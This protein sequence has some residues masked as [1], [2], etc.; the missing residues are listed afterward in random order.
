MLLFGS[1][2]GHLHSKHPYAYVLKQLVTLPSLA[3]ILRG[4]AWWKQTRHSV[5]AMS[6]ATLLPPAP[7]S[8]SP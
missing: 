3:G 4:T 6:K 5:G 7:E 8:L 2:G 1:M